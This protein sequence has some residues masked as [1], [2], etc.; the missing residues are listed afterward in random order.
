[1]LCPSQSTFYPECFRNFAEPRVAVFALSRLVCLW[2]SNAVILHCSSVGLIVVIIGSAQR[3]AEIIFDDQIHWGQAFT[4]LDILF[5]LVLNS[6]QMVYR[7][8]GV[9]DRAHARSE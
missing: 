5:C 8:H 4:C 9:I 6:L 7:M 2:R 1:V 3:L